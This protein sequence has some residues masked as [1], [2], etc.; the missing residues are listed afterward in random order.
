MSRWEILEE[1]KKKKYNIFVS[2]MTKITKKKNQKNKKTFKPKVNRKSED[3]PGLCQKRWGKFSILTA[4]RFL[5]KISYLAVI[6][7]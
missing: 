6:G 7:N 5:Q 2:K 1:L 4:F 3:P